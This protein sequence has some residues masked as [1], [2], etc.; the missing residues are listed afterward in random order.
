L[1][2]GP[3]LVELSG[4]GVGR[5]GAFWSLTPGLTGLVELS[6]EELGRSGEELGR[7]GEELGRSGATGGVA[8]FGPRGAELSDA[9]GFEGVFSV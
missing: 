1:L 3:G 6:G 9:G 4:E 2:P 5:S 7:S 8:S